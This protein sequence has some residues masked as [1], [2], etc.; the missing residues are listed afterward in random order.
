[1]PPPD[2]DLDSL[3]ERMRKDYEVPGIAVEIVKDGKPVVLK[4][5]GIRRVN[6]PESVD[7]QTLFNIGSNTKGFTA[8][9]LALLAEEGKLHWGDPVTKHLPGF[10]MYDAWVTREMTIRDLLAHR[11]GLGLGAGDLLFVWPPTTFTREDIV[12]RQRFIKLATSFRSGYAYDNCVYI[13]AGEVVQAASGKTWEEFVVE[14]LFVPLGMH[15]SSINR[16]ALA[17]DGNKAVSHIW[18]R[19]RLETVGYY[20]V[21]N[22]AP[23]GGINSCAADMAKWAKTLL[24]AADARDSGGGPPPFLARSS[25]QQLWSAQ[26]PMPIEQPHP[27]GSIVK[28]QFSAY[29]LG[30][31]FRDYRGNKLVWHSGGM[32]GQISWV[33]LV[34]ELS[35]GIILLSNKEPNQGLEALTYHILDKYLSAPSTTDWLGVFREAAD[36]E[37]TNAGATVAELGK[38]R[39]HATK[40]SLALADYAGKYVDSWYGEMDLVLEKGQLVLRFSHTPALVGDLEHWQYDSFVV[41]WRD[42]SFDADAFVYFTVNPEG[43]VESMKMKPVSPLTDFSF[44]FQ[45]LDFKPARKQKM[46]SQ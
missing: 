20:N 23:A 27:M 13:V 15:R 41:R 14:R 12:F 44:D 8:A 31:A 1:M 33:T 5:Y 43:G 19:G 29:G 39:T 3:V 37:R 34:P 46:D 4:G 21:T 22:M 40:P 17:N 9:A 7:E 16:E 38:K 10:Q 36:Q 18:N 35:L 45:D 30:F 24:A 25:I 11:S 26:T 6:E 28:P 2:L 42:H 32:P